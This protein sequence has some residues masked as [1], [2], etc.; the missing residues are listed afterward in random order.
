MLP[1]PSFYNPDEASVLRVERAAL[2]A[3]VARD[4]ARAHCIAPAARDEVRIAAFGIDCQVAFCHPDASLFVPGAVEDT[5]RT[6]AWLYRHIDRITQ[7]VFSLDTHRVFQI[8]HPAWW[9]DR[10]GHPPLPFTTVTVEDLRSGRIRPAREEHLAEA[11]EYVERLEAEGRNP[12]T[13]WPYHALLG[14]IGH[15]LVPA[16]MEAA[17]FHGLVRGSQAHFELKGEHP[18]TENYSVFAPEVR[19][20]GGRA[21]GDFNHRLF[22]MLMGYDRVY[23]FG[24]AKSHC[25]LATLRDVR[26]RIEAVDRSLMKKIFVLEDAMSPVPAPRIDPL[27]AELDFP[28]RAAAALEELRSAGMNVVR[29]TDAID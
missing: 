3:E 27:P 2:V 13:I 25:V 9:I 21:V 28:S 10:D 8:F 19:R 1:L 4:F 20:I 17:I 6:L 11:F 26:A 16:F 23:V 14:G 22:D 12:L 15:A 29:T 5:A 24:Q 7:L 18:S